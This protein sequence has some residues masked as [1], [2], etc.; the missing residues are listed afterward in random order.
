MPGAAS[1][2]SSLPMAEA[3]DALVERLKDLPGL[4]RRSA[5]RVALQLV[6]DERGASAAL[7]EAL[8]RAER[9]LEACPHCGNLSQRGEACA[10]CTD[11]T[12]ERRALCVVERIPD[13][14]AFENSGSWR[15]LYH[16]LGGKL[17][18]LQD[19]G[20]ESIRL[21]SLGE[22]IAAL[23]VE[24]LV[25]ALSNDVEGEATCH[26]IAE[27]FLPVDREVRVSRIGFGLPSAGEI[28][29][30]DAVT[31]RSALESRRAFE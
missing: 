15:G 14:R 3:F 16:V 2:K 29:Y 6:T 25:L 24:E 23:E 1:G 22:R 4:G 18:P 28:P 10:V 12:R 21:A 27:Q 30:A 11:P 20:P 26:Y 19:R 5:E 9:E 31:L 8:E 13:L 17:S 7:R